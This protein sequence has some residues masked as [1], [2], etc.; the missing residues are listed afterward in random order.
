MVTAGGLDQFEISRSHLIENHRVLLFVVGDAVEV[1]KSS[2]GRAKG[3]DRG[4]IFGLAGTDRGGFA[5]VVD[6]GSGGGDGLRVAAE[7]E[8]FERDNAELLFEQ[9][10]GVVG[11]KN[12][13]FEAGF[14]GSEAVEFG[15]DGG[16]EERDWAGEEDFARA[17]DAK[18]V[19][20]AGFGIVAGE[21]GGAEFASGKVNESETGGQALRVA[22]DGGEEVVLFAFDKVGGGGAGREN[23]DHFATDDLF[24]GSR[25]FEL[26]ADGDFVA[27]ADEAG[28]VV[29]GGMIGHA[30]HWDGFAALFVAGGEGDLQDAGGDDRVVVK[31]FVEI[32]EAEEEQRLRMLFFHGVV[33]LHQRSSWLGHGQIMR[34]LF[35]RLGDYGVGR[36]GWQPSRR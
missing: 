12:P 21:F 28:D 29:F 8:T 5:E 27:G 18:L 20:E 16:R 26:F 31:E 34:K 32:A 2:A 15:R 23:T 36:A 22:R 7:A 25:L 14:D 24:A 6:D 4:G 11:L 30:A 10:A 3:R 33:L 19:A 13:F 9:A 17:K 35:G 1:L